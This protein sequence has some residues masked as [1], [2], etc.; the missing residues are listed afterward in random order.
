MLGGVRRGVV[1]GQGGM[2]V[3]ESKGQK[4]LKG[5]NFKLLSPVKEN[6]MTLTSKMTISLNTPIFSYIIQLIYQSN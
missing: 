4:I 5:I 2:V 3:V 1:G 6:S